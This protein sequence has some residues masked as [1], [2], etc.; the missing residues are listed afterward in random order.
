MHDKVEREA[1]PAII[2]GLKGKCPNCHKGSLFTKYLKSAHSCDNCGE[3]LFHNRTDDG[4][5]YITVLIIV[6]VIGILTHSLF[7]SFEGHMLAFTVLL[8]TFATTLALFMLPRVKGALIGLQ[9]AKRMHG[10]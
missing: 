3:E 6:H 4:P 2:D 10:F 8:M 9:W 1:K 7:G 5:A